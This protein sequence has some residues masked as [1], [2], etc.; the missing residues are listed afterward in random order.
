MVALKTIDPPLSA[1]AGRTIEGTRRHGKM[2]VVEFSD[3]LSL[4]VHLMS[5][6]PAP[7][8]RQA[9][10]AA[11]PGLARPDPA[12]RRARAAPARVRDQAARVGEAA[13]RR[14]GRERRD[15]RDARARG[16]AGPAARRA[17]G[18]GGPAP[19]P[20]SAAARPAGDR[21]NRPPVG[22]RDPLGSAALALQEGIRAGG[23]GGR[24]T[25][26]RA[27]RAGRRDRPLRGGRRRRGPEQAAHAASGP[28]A[29]GRAVPALRHD[30][31]GGVLRRAPDEL[32]PGRSKRAD[33]S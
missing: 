6:G 19:P 16:V 31:R 11:R 18:G 14:R 30:D 5:A 29:R 22:R 8:F 23:G 25:P 17:R 10:L 3:G 33:G 15:G 2:P 9:C 13:A 24:A 28:Q 21:R 26:R 7:G 4:L 20:P 27:P 1:L 12:R 32:L